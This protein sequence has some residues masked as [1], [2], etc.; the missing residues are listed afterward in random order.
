[1]IGPNFG[2]PPFVLGFAPNADGTFTLTWTGAML[3][4]A[5]SVMGPWTTNT[6]AV[7]PLTVTPDKAMKQM[8][9]RLQAQ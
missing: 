5:T 6:A 1:V 9:Y 4:E 3:L 8:Y 2:N 7:S